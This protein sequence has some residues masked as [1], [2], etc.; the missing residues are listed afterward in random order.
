VRALNQHYRLTDDATG[1][2]VLRFDD[3]TEYTLEEAMLIAKGRAKEE[4][5]RAIHLVKREF[6]GVLEGFPYGLDKIMPQPDP[7]LQKAAP[8]QAVR[9]VAR[10]S[11]PGKNPGVSDTVQL[12]LWEAEHESD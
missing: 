10:K 12:N 4:D 11:K 3:G 8:V 1:K 7:A 9:K 5:V 2:V 6:H